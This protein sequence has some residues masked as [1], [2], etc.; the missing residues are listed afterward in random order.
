[1][2]HPIKHSTDIR[3]TNTPHIVR[4]PCAVF[5]SSSMPTRSGAKPY[6][7]CDIRRFIRRVPF[8]MSSAESCDA[9]GAA[10]AIVAS[11]PVVGAEMCASSEAVA[12]TGAN[13]EDDGPMGGSSIVSSAAIPNGAQDA[14]VY[15]QEIPPNQEALLAVP[16]H[17]DD[18]AL[19]SADGNGVSGGGDIQPAK[20]QRVNKSGAVAKAPPKKGKAKASAQ[21][22][23]R[24]AAA[25]PVLC[26][27]AAA[28]PSAVHKAAAKAPNVLKPPPPGPP[29]IT[30]AMAKS[31]T[32][33]PPPG[34]CAIVPAKPP[35]SVPE[36]RDAMKA[37][38]FNSMW[39]ARSLPQECMTLIEEAAQARARGD[40]LGWVR[41][42]Y[43]K[44]SSDQT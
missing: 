34:G 31:C 3:P 2:H 25:V 27:P 35:P 8:A 39:A 42:R 40:L 22:L 14:G 16:E 1:M 33:A 19:V 38:R 37:R 44:T 30:A 41:L 5:G 18:V 7:V 24:P 23:G 13:Y 10:D 12:E 26:R 20:R 29:Q 15:S 11:G 43:I 32:G 36:M 17:P 28:P 6:R 9:M 4:F 21:V